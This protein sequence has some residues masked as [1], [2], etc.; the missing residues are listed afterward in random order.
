MSFLNEFVLLLKARYPIIYIST[1]EEER[2]EQII[3]YCTKKYVS[4]TYYSW[5]FV[6]GYQGNPNDTGFAAKNPLEALELV[7]KL[8]A[9]TASV[10]VLKDYDNFLKDLSIIRKLKNL[11]LS[12]KTQP[13]NLIIISSEVNI[14]ETLREFV[15]LIEFPLPTSNEINQELSRLM[16]SLNQNSSDELLLSLTTACQ[17]LSMARIR[18]VLS[19][20]IAQSG[21]IDMSS[22]S[23][24]LEEKKQI[25]QQTQLLEFSLTDKKVTD[26]GGLDNFKDWLRLRSEAF[27]P[28]AKEYGLPYPKGLL[29]VG[30]QGTGK[31]LAAKTVANEWN[32]PLLRLDF[33]RL[34]ASL[35]GQS[36]SQ[37]RKMIQ[38]AEALAPCV[39]WVDEIDKA[40]A[41]AQN[42]GDSGTTS[43]VLSTFLTWMSE[44]NS[45]VFVVATANNIEWIPPEII[46]KGRFDEVFFLSLP[47]KEERQSI[48]EVH[49]KKARP[50]RIQEFTLPL[51]SDLTKDFS[52]AE[53]EQVVIEAMRLGYSKRKDFE[54][55]DILASIQKIVPLARTKNKELTLLQKWFEAGNVVSASKYR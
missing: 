7:D 46:R 28:A 12:L 29:L 31:S 9:E 14:P 1:S 2:L 5:D 53:I 3:K 11:S 27:L 43:R 4:R 10:F 38:I 21:N 42:S 25:I 36:E 54:T 16:T 50:E 13:K 33:G 39:L 22:P 44:K 30:V 51:L 45:P 26:L 55:E 15:T 35:V 19:K 6:D 18:R 17:G 8:T 49:L 23:L 48:F 41:G 52:G 40:F 34:F 20:V 32:L 24:V 47:T 37:V